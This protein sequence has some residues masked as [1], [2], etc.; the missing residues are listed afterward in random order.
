MKPKVLL[1]LALLLVVVTGLALAGDAGA[2]TSTAK[3]DGS[4]PTWAK[5][6]GWDDVT[7]LG[8][9]NGIFTP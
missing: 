6:A 5:A 9:P 4:A 7:G 1:P 2:A 8:V 3:L